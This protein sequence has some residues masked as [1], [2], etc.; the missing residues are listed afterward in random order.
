MKKN[1]YTQKLRGK[2]NHNLEYCIL[3]KIANQKFLQE[4]Y[5]FF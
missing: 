5:T 3:R 1:Q 4:T 2:R